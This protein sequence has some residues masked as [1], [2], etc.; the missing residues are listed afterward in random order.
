MFH[1][2]YDGYLEHAY[3]YDELRPLSCDGVDTWGSYS[4][5]LIDA[6]DTLAIMG[7]YT[8]F[9]RVYNLVAMR[10]NFDA[11]INVSVFETNIRIVGGLLSAHLFARKAGVELEPGWPCTG[12]LLRLAEDAA[13]RLL[14]AFDTPTGMPFG[15]VNL[16]NGVPNG[17]TPVTSTAGVGTMVIEFGALS[18]LT[19]KFC[20]LFEQC[21]WITLK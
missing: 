10:T 20:F 9:K 16:Q 14:P 5:T 11:N 17:E 2:A 1:W 21:L 6:L 18:R 4:L 3:P 15:T 19:G 8:E 12:P 13:S 7:N